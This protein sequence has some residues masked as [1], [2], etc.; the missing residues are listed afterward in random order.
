MMKTLLSVSDPI[1]FINSSNFSS[2]N[3]HQVENVKNYFRRLMQ[4]VNLTDKNNKEVFSLKKQLDIIVE[5]CK[6]KEMKIKITIDAIKSD[7]EKNIQK[8]LTTL[9]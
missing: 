2:K 6:E 9:D 7:L 1:A 8:I 3:T 4:F 5:T